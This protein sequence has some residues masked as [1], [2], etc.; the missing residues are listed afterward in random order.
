MPLLLVGLLSGCNIAKH[1]PAKERLYDGT[2][3]VMKADS[4][5]SADETKGAGRAVADPGP[6]Q[7]QQ[8][9]VRVPV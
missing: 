7:A 1:L 5:V 2:D 3:F 9:T 8:E 4:T 6:A